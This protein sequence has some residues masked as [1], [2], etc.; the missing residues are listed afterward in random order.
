MADPLQRR[1]DHHPRTASRVFSGEA[2][3][4]TPAENKVRM[5]NAAGSRIWEL[6]DGSR[7]V[8]EIVAVLTDEFDVDPERAQR[9][10]LE[11]LDTLAEQDLIVWN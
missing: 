1:P 5:L 11:L 2:V 9:T 7:S 3:V 8:A 10:T 6:A 4:I